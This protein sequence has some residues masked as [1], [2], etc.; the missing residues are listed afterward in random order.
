MVEDKQSMV[1][2]E[3]SMVEDEQS[4]VEDEQSM[5]EDEQSM[6]EDEQSMVEDEQ[7]MVEDKQTIQDIK[8]APISAP[9]A[10]NSI[11]TPTCTST[12][13]QSEFIKARK[14]SFS[15]H[16]IETEPRELKI[17]FSKGT[18]NL[19]PEHDTK[20]AIYIT[21]LRDCHYLQPSHIFHLAESKPQR[22]HR[23]TPTHSIR[24]SLPRCQTNQSSL[25]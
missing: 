13:T 14:N 7:S 6:V 4:M 20:N 1:E 21:Q 12:E 16:S 11:N 17:E 10:S 19:A 8:Q 24:Y 5:V 15:S 25:T 3:Q 23:V 2:D 22:N 18:L 9:K